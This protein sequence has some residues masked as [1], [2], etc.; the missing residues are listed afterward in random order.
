MSLFR[1]LL[2][3]PERREFSLSRWEWFLDGGWA[4]SSTGEIITEDRA[5]TI[6]A[7]MACVRII[8]E[9]IGSLPLT[10]YQ[11]TPDGGKKDAVDEDLYW[12]L[13]ETPNSE[14]TRME[15]FETL[16]GH[17]AIRGNAFTEIVRNSRGYPLELNILHPDQV[18][19]RRKNGILI[20]EVYPLMGQ[21][22][23]RILF[24][25]DIM[26]FRLF[27]SN[28]ITG[29]SP[30]EFARNN[31]GLAISQ[32][33]HASKLFSNG[34]MPGGMLTTD[35]SL[36]QDEREA[37]KQSWQ[38]AHG[39]VKNA[40]KIAFLS[41]GIKWQQISMN[42][43]DAQF[44]ESRRFQLAEIARIFRVP[45]HL[46]Q[47]LERSTNNNI[48]HQS[49]E[50]VVHTIRPWLVRW[51]SAIT[52]DLLTASQK[53]RGLFVKFNHD[54]LLRGDTTTQSEAITKYVS[55]GIYSRN[56]A[57]EILDRNPIEGGDEYLV[58]LN[59]EPVGKNQNDNATKRDIIPAQNDA[60][61]VQKRAKNAFRALIQD[62]SERI[63]S[64]DVAA[65]RKNA[66]K[67]RAKDFQDWMEKFFAE[68]QEFFRS[69]MTPLAQK[70]A[71]GIG[72]CDSR[73]ISKYID[74]L[75]SNYHSGSLGDIQLAMDS[76]RN[77]EDPEMLWSTFLVKLDSVLSSWEQTRAILITESVFEII[78]REK[79]S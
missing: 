39:G 3:M 57:R 59:M 72:E 22:T 53:R 65:I 46:L 75:S 47:E 42:A 76:C 16:S 35:N 45:L 33:E 37:A 78:E 25:D 30:I 12:L 51:E 55:G 6:P 19:V 64:K 24:S 11:Q 52:R 36:R 5:Y 66:K 61:I 40:H 4:Q 77:L 18:R 50:F 44:L 34:A 69:Q 26:H 74:Q 14:N 13:K 49:I 79:G 73:E 32:E 15:F 70:V 41:G 7:V 62:I 38:A 68:Q 63:V 56:E 54:A 20:Y 71:D 17:G 1:T 67:L 27:S 28:G 43:E 48:E 10:L 23:P 31:F 21:G 60:K 58:P 2:G 9:T 29:M 8:A